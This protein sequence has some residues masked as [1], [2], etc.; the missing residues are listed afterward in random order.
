MCGMTRSRT[1][2]GS[3][4]FIRQHDGSIER[5]VVA[6][7]FVDVQQPSKYLVHLPCPP[8]TNIHYGIVNY[9]ITAL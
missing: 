2:I 6:I 9:D 8:S 5:L 4:P 1:Y 3:E 7:V